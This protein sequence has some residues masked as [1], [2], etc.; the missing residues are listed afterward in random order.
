LALRWLPISLGVAP[1][2]RKA[3]VDSRDTTFR[4]AERDSAAITSS[5]M[6][7]PND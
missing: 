7:S 3:V 1:R 2:P 5:A 4:S 6:I